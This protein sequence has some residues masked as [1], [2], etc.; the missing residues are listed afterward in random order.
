MCLEFGCP[1]PVG[2]LQVLW[3]PPQFK[4]YAY[5]GRFDTEM[6]PPLMCALTGMCWACDTM[7][8]TMDVMFSITHHFVINKVYLKG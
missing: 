6:A 8:V 3:F 7:D 5:L 2:F 1:Q 4:N